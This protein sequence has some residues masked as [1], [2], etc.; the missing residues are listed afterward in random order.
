M[1]RYNTHPDVSIHE[2]PVLQAAAAV[3]PRMGQVLVAASV[4]TVDPSHGR[5]ALGRVYQ[6]GV[7]PSRS[8]NNSRSNNMGSDECSIAS[9]GGCIESG[10]VFVRACVCLRGLIASRSAQH[11]EPRMQ[12]VRIR[13]LK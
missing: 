4:G 3:P 7:T 2:G 9:T 12:R 6:A 13:S 5:A 10:G 1:H 11:R 8:S